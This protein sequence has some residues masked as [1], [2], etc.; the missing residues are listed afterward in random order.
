MR[1]YGAAAV[2]HSFLAE[3]ARMADVAAIGRALG[4][5]ALGI[6]TVAMRVPELAIRTISWNLST[7]LFPALSR[8][9]ESDEASVGRTSLELTRLQALYILPVAAGLTALATPLVIV[10]FS[11][12]WA[13]AGEVMAVLSILAACDVVMMPLG[14]AMRATGH[15]RALVWVN[16]VSVPATIAGVIIAAPH[17]IVAV[18]WTLV[19]IQTAFS[20]MVAFA[21]VRTIHIRA[22]DVVRSLIPGLIAAAGT[23][24]AASAV[25]YGWDEA[26]L[27]PVAVAALAGA[28]GAVAALRVFAAGTFGEV[29]VVLRA[30]FPSPRRAPAP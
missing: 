11:D 28:V 8:R 4:E 2:A 18:A 22:I 24:A 6:Y 7:V 19:G 21:A 1:S 10:L 15:Q 17:G 9:R 5:R 14:D 26:S 3:V 23:A 27:V 20:V 13:A 30:A 16:A 29:L 12:T 25:R